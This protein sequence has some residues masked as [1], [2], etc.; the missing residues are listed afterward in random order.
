MRLLRLNAWDTAYLITGAQVYTF[1]IFIY[2]SLIIDELIHFSM[3]L[4]SICAPF[5]N[6]LLIHK[7]WWAT[8]P[9]SFLNGTG[10]ALGQGLA[11]LFWHFGFSGHATSFTATLPHKQLP[12][13][14]KWVGTCY[15]PTKLYLQKH[16]GQIWPVGPSLPTSALV[17]PLS[18]IS[19]YYKNTFSVTRVFFPWNNK[20]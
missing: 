13:T 14:W 8:L 18:L 11:K 6:C 2:I 10:T 7:D 9:W 4:L 20:Y 3:Y 1:I 16:M 12:T 5:V 19:S 17:P 15:V